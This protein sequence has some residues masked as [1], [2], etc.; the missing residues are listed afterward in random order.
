MTKEERNKQTIIKFWEAVVRQNPDPEIWKQF[1]S[2]TDY[3]EH[4]Q[5]G[6]GD[7]FEG[8]IRRF[9][10]VFKAFPGF[11]IDVEAVLADGDMVATRYVDRGAMKGEFLGLPPTG[12]SYVMDGMHF[13][14]F[15]EEGKI[16]EHWDCVNELQFF[17]Q[18]GILDTVLEG[19][20][21]Q[22]AQNA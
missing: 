14:R 16:V 10:W 19:M 4:H 22:A 11:Q 20:R 17:F 1:F 18:L 13:F 8:L 2:E 12:K 7:G 15:N 9:Q 6:Q 3:K 5:F 21:A